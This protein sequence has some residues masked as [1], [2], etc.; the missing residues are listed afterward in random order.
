MLRGKESKKN[1]FISFKELLPRIIVKDPVVHDSWEK[2][3]FTTYLICIKTEHPAFHLWLSAVRRRFSEV[4]WLYMILKANHS[5]VLFPKVPSKK[6]FAERFEPEFIKSRM[7]EIQC[8]LNELLVTDTVL[9]DAAFH[10]FIQTDLTTDEIEEHLNGTLPESIMD[11][12]WENAGHLHT[13]SYIVNTTIIPHEPQE[14]VMN[15][16]DLQPSHQRSQSLNSSDS[17]TSFDNHSVS[18][19]ETKDAPSVPESRESLLNNPESLTDSNVEPEDVGTQSEVVTLSHDVVIN[20]DDINTTESL[21]EL[22]DSSLDSV[23]R[24]AD[25]MKL[26]LPV[27]NV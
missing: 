22:S 19:T 21:L 8:F 2:G 13:S 3:K 26:T 27:K 7:M 14:I 17:H 4:R 23:N 16:E 10:I 6:V 20:D 25:V 1:K 18:M 12:A 9:A 5:H 15:E 24:S 11:K